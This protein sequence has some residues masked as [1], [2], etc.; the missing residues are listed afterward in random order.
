VERHRPDRPKLTPPRLVDV[1]G[2]LLL[3]TASA[4]LVAVAV[5]TA[6]R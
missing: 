2:G 3:L 6:A 1:V 5:V 4:F